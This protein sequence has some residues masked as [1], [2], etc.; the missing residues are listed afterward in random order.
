MAADLEKIASV[1]D[2]LRKRATFFEETD[3]ASVDKE[4]FGMIA[5]YLQGLAD[6]L[7]H[8]LIGDAKKKIW[9]GVAAFFL[10][11]GGFIGIC[12]LFNQYNPLEAK[13]YAKLAK[14]IFAD[15]AN[16]VFYAKCLQAG[17]ALIAG[18]FIFFVSF[19]LAVVVCS[20]VKAIKSSWMNTLIEASATLLAMGILFY[21]YYNIVYITDLAKKFL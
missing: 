3:P 5:N 11:V 8:A 7:D 17:V 4:D 2:L 12:L 9:L 10:Y 6:A 19:F 16:N 1:A 21:Y 15:E 18:L 13:Y 20:I 14:E